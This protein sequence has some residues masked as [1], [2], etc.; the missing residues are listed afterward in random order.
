[1]EHMWRG[2]IAK[3]VSVLLLTAL[4]VLLYFFRFRVP[5]L[6]DMFSVE[7]SAFSELIVSLAY[8]PLYG[9]AVC[10]VKNAIHIA[11]HT[12]YLITDFSNFI[13]ESVFVAVSGMIYIRKMFPKKLKPEKVFKR[14]YKHKS[15]FFASFI[16]IICTLVMQFLTTNFFVY[17]MLINKYYN[18]GYTKENVIQTYAGAIGAIGNHL[19]QSLAALVPQIK[20]I[21]QGVLLINLPITFAKLFVIVVLTV[22]IYPLL[23]PILHYRFKPKGVEISE[24]ANNADTF[25]S[26]N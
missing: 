25:N 19:S 7:F 5:L 1:M 4:S 23:S 2:H 21:W 11:V 13:V 20:S 12:N 8:G 18:A 17:P 14:T 3:V 10:F 6:S 22:I 24:K 26:C 16:G 9:V 15:L